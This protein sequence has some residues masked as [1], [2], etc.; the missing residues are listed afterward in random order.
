MAGVHPPLVTWMQDLF[1]VAHVDLITEPGP[2]RMVAQTPE[3]ARELLRAKVALSVTGHAS[4]LLVLARQ[5]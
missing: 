4:R 2:D 5:S 3:R 1:S